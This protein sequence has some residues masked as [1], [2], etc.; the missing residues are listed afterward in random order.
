MVLSQPHLFKLNAT[1]AESLYE[2]RSLKSLTVST[3]NYENSAKLRT[4]EKSLQQ[5]QESLSAGPYPVLGKTIS[6]DTRSY[7]DRVYAEANAYNWKDLPP[8]LML[9]LEKRKVELN[10]LFTFEKE[11]ITQLSFVNDEFM[12]LEGRFISIINTTTALNGL[13]LFA[14]LINSLSL[15]SVNICLY[16]KRFSVNYLHSQADLLKPF[17]QLSVD[18]D[19]LAE[20]LKGFLSDEIPEYRSIRDLIVKELALKGFENRICPLMISFIAQSNLAWEDL[21]KVQSIC[22]EMQMR[23]SL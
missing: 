21:M 10:K 3:E 11:N 5:I 2:V 15:N 9:A 4:M 7:Y 20:N 22:M 17:F 23:Y 12:K 13:D 14:P 8:F 1:I 6:S 16:P 19:Q 18:M